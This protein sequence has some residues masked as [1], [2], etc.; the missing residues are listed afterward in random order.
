MIAVHGGAGDIPDERVQGKITGVLEAARLGRLVL[1]TGGTALDACEAAVRYMEKDENFNAGRG[2]VL[3]S[4]GTLE[5]EAI[6]MEGRDLRAGGVTMLDCT[7]HPITAARLVMQH[8]PHVLL[9]G[10]GAR[11]IVTEHG[12]PQCLPED[13]ITDHARRALLRPVTEART[14][15]GG[16]III[17]KISKYIS[18]Y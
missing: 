8:T 7:P 3:T 15:I 16:N 18:I 4:A 14:E 6:V 9:A 13:L 5:M 10:E 2:S 17:M 12:L 11:K 1:E